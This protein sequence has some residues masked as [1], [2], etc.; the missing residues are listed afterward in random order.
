[1]SPRASTLQA[2]F[3]ELKRRRVF[4]VVAVYGAVAFVV[5]QVADLAFP[6]LGMPEWTVT[7]VLMLSLLGL[8]AA[9]VLAWAFETTPDGWKRTESAEPAEIDAI[10]AEPRSRR[11]PAGFAALGGIALLVAGAW[12]MG[13]RSGVAAGQRSEAGAANGIHTIA[14]LPLATR[15][16]G[17][18][19]GVDDVVLFAD[20]MHDD[21]LTQLSRVQG[22]RVTSRTSVEEFRN[23]DL[24]I[25]A[26]AERLGV[27]YIVEGAVDRVGDRVRVNV[28]LIDAGSDG[29][30]WANT[31]DQTMTLDNLFAIR[32]DLTRR[33][34]AS[35]RATLSPAVEAKI[36]E[37]PTDNAEAFELYTRARHLWER[38][39]RT[40]LEQAVEL[41]E[42][43]VALD[44]RFSAAHATLAAV[45]TRILAFGFAPRGRQLPLIRE[46]VGRALEIDT[47]NAQALVY[48]A[49][50]ESVGDGD[51]RRARETLERV[52]ELNPSSAEAYWGLAS[53]DGALGY[54]YRALEYI[55][56]A[57]DL[58]PLSAGIG[59][60][61]V[62]RMLAVGR[63]DEALEQASA[64]LELHPDYEPASGAL[65]EALR[66]AGRHEETVRVQE[67]AV[68]RNPRSIFAA[69]GLAW[70]YFNVSRRAEALAQI[71]SAVATTPDDFPM[72]G[73]LMRMLMDAG[74]YEAAL[75]PAREQ[76]RLAPG[77]AGAREGLALVLLA[78]GDTAA[79]NAQLDTALAS[80][81]SDEPQI[82][83]GLRRAGR[84]E[85]AVAELREE[86]RE[87]PESVWRRVELAR[88]L[89][90]LAPWAE[91]E[92]SEA[93][94]EFAAARRL[95]PR[96][97]FLLRSYGQTLRE[98][99]RTDESLAPY[100][101]LR[102][103]QP[104]DSDAH[105]GLGWDLLIG[106][107]DLDAAGRSFRRAVEL[108]P[109]AEGALWGLARVD[110]RQGRTEAGL[111]AMNNLIETC[112]LTM[113]RPYFGVRAAWLRAVAGDEAGARE[114]LDRFEGM[115]DHPDYGEW[116]PVLAAARGE[117]GE[118]DRAFDL[119]NRAYDLRSTRLLEL[120]VEPWFDPL[121]DDAR[122][123]ALLRKMGL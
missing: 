48:R 108:N 49:Y 10:M 4:R 86:V 15:S 104:N 92:A 1:M 119:L 47:D 43:A 17:G 123:G 115:R 50:V 120:K 21:L 107:R 31:Y 103:D 121:R 19:E 2:F 75:A 79:A 60:D 13:Q 93:L 110:V 57:R 113:C 97:D 116:L 46:A 64:V 69:E 98:L 55:R 68:R 70:A 90:E 114:L 59:V 94:A 14:V 76:V 7:L 71:R 44:P 83:E 41:L 54:E 74:Q 122:F 40:D 11:W 89:F 99:G 3:A 80:A 73:T 84:V 24:N 33:I 72:Q 112:G 42:R 105:M 95:S 37:R 23:T 12:W 30:I 36:A 9:I 34:A 53:L 78:V 8:P 58:D 26:I 25:T 52:I 6:L 51:T 82:T 102:D 109:R 32:D 35:L 111:A 16:A 85:E 96:E 66:A 5:L 106:Q 100:E 38:G 62:N 81:A 56:R 65:H 22:L 27:E 67:R 117:L 118:R 18:G 29:H 20:G 88:G 87:D 39:M 63:N 28:Q 77:V 91:H 45:H 61:L 101:A